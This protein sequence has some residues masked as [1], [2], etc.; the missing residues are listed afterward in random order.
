MLLRRTL[1]RTSPSTAAL[2]RRQW[3]VATS[4]VPSWPPEADSVT[5]EELRTTQAGGASSLNH[6]ELDGASEEDMKYFWD[7]YGLPSGLSGSLAGRAFLRGGVWADP[8]TLQDRVSKLQHITKVPL[9]K[10]MRQVPELV[11]Y[12]PET[13]KSK[14]LTLSKA[15]PRVDVL[16]M[17]RRRPSLL[18]RSSSFLSE[19]TAM[20]LK[21]LPR[22]DMQHVAAEAPGLLEVSP[23]EIS[24]R[25]AAIRRLYSR[26]TLANWQRPHAVRLL[27]TP[28][29]KLAQLEYVDRLNPNIRISIPDRRILEMSESQFARHFVKTSQAHLNRRLEAPRGVSARGMK[30]PIFDDVTIPDMIPDGDLLK[31]GAAHA[32]LVRSAKSSTANH[33]S[34]G[35]LS[36]CEPSTNASMPMGHRALNRAR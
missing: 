9:A 5:E 29:R 20:L 18:R 1:A 21:L 8:V 10:L 25:A 30:S 35:T 28:M 32:R 12:R 14:L 11:E 27:Q 24:N 34:H 31:W 3:R 33:T 13:V 23:P 7:E 36:S 2:S 6:G 19:R 26:L 22:S 17:A 4:A 15:L 16:Q